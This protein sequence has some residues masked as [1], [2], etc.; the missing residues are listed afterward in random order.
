[1]ARML[2]DSARGTDTASNALPMVY[3]NMYMLLV[4]DASAD[5]AAETLASPSEGRPSVIK[6]STVVHVLALPADNEACNN[7]DACC[8]AAV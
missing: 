6:S 2:Q 8:M 5:A 1:M 3:T 4:S 7:V